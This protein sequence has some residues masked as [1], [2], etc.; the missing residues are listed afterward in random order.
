[1][2][3]EEAVVLMFDV[4]HPRS[5][6]ECSMSLSVVRCLAVGRRTAAPV[7]GSPLM[8]LWLP[9]TCPRR[10]ELATPSSVGGTRASDAATETTGNCSMPH[11]LR[12][13]SNTRCNA[14]TR[15]PPRF[16]TF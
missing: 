6:R 4:P 16:A 12:M 11:C 5:V 9:S 1:V 8:W 3:S 2:G 10:I 13:M 14:A 15:P 7:S